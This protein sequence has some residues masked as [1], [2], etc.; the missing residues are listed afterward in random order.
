MVIIPIKVRKNKATRVTVAMEVKLRIK[1][2]ITI[3][4]FVFRLMRRRGLTT[5]KV[6]RTLKNPKLD[7]PIIILTIDT[8][9][10]QKSSIFHPFSI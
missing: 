3:F 1:L 5:L 10:M 7:P 9:T 2:F 6:R 4:R 8:I